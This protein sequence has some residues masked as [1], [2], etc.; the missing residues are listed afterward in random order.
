MKVLSLLRMVPF[1]LGMGMLPIEFSPQTALVE[2]FLLLTFSGTVK[3]QDEKTDA[4]WNW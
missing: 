2:G 3:Q 1:M 4:S